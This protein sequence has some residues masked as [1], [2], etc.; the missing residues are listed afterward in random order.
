MSGIR[1]TS[2]SDTYNAIVE[3][4][5]NINDGEI[6]RVEFSISVN[7]GSAATTTVTSREMWTPD[8]T[9]F[10]DPLPPWWGLVLQCGATVLPFL[11]E[12]TQWVTLKLYLPSKENKND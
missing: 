5:H 2:S 4:F 3:A 10:G 11:W 9:L 8:D 7:G 12:A 1:R 6:D